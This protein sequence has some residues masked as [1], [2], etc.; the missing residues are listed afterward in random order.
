MVNFF[1]QQAAARR[2]TA[3]CVGLYALAV[4]GVV[5]CVVPVMTGL[6]LYITAG[7]AGSKSERARAISQTVDA[8]SNDPVGYFTEP[9]HAMLVGVSL[10]LT[11][12]LIF[13]SSLVK[14]IGLR[15][16]GS[17]V[18]QGLGARRVPHGTH[19]LAERRLLN[20]VEEMALASSVPVPD[21]FVMEE[22]GINAFAA[23][24][25][26]S[27]A[28]VA[29]TRGALQRLNREQLQGVIAHEFSHIL[30]GD[31]RLNL[32]LMVLLFGIGCV[33]FLGRILLELR[34][35]RKNPLPFVGIVLMVIGAVGVFF[36][37]LIRAMISRQREFLADASAVQFTRNPDGLAGALKVIGGSGVGGRIESVKAAEC[38]HMM[39]AS[40]ESKLFSGG[41]LAA[42]HPPIEERIR[43]LDPH[44]DG[45][46][47]I[48]GPAAMIKPY[49]G[50]GE[51]SPEIEYPADASDL[52]QLLRPVGSAAVQATP[53]AIVGAPA[54]S[55]AALAA[56]R[57]ISPAEVLRRVHEARGRTTTIKADL[58]DPARD[59]FTARALLLAM[60]L[61]ADELV[62]HTQLAEI[63]QRLGAPTA[64]NAVTLSSRLAK[65][66]RSVRLPL[67][68]VAVG[69][70]AAM[71]REQYLAFRDTLLGVIKA[72]NRLDIFELCLEQIVV[73]NLDRRH[74]DARLPTVQF[75]T[76]RRMGGQIGSLLA[77]VAQAA[78]GGVIDRDRIA[79]LLRE[80]GCD[81]VPDTLEA[82]TDKSNDTLVLLRTVA[83]KL[84]TRYSAPAPRSLG[85][86]IALTR[87]RK[88]SSGPS[89]RPST[90]RWVPTRRR[91]A[92]SLDMTPRPR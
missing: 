78:E 29:V 25:S 55:D 50:E 18:A 88:S 49:G 76:L 33:G 27:D 28:A 37:G 59:P 83:P 34:G 71:S 46:F 54:P 66:P 68:E 87:P 36:A 3:L 85:P 30:N 5:V 44:W 90:C 24:H 21:V 53:S 8:V 15:Q 77:T 67:I 91:E 47:T 42:T 40:P 41:G 84:R 72:D 80:L 82:S 31:M 45:K 89:P 74:L 2:R 22:S 63:T 16:G 48:T 9:S 13:G 81:T 7:T 43:R 17:A 20:I 62:R 32:R 14:Y 38:S 35:G 64:S 23:G 61:D 52:I 75:Y 70:L 26:P 60:L 65:A 19:D 10:A 79:R 58:A 1:E 92:Q 56:A 12:A 73:T 57:G 39:F 6:A 4:L 51:D 69:T 11:L 86:T